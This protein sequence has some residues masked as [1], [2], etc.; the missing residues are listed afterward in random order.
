MES[1][2]PK[3]FERLKGKRKETPAV[4]KVR[5]KKAA[6]APFTPEDA[7]KI[8]KT[9]KVEPATPAPKKKAPKAKKAAAKKKPAPNLDNVPTEKKSYQAASIADILGFNPAASKPK[10]ANEA[11]ERVA[12]KYK[13]WY[14]KL[15]DMRTQLQ[16]GINYHTEETLRRSSRD[17]SGDLSG[18]G[19]HQADAGT[20]T[21][22]RDLAL[23]LVSSEQEALIEIEEAIQRIF[24]GTYG[25]C[26]MTGE[27]IAEERLEAVPFA[28]HSV[29]GQAE[30]E[31]TNRRKI[32]RGN[33][34]MDEDEDAPRLA[35]DDD[36]E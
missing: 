3:A 16:E 8:I 2:Q 36:E 25:V 34:F 12:P 32:E 29:E 9:R 26:E 1:T 20:E 7:I 17:D 27:P 18:Y 21:F 6:A 28:R 33:V 4:F 10:P 35:N 22:D 14:K 19:Q 24:N 5:T 30:Y 23:S 11:D 31:R 15:L 13:K